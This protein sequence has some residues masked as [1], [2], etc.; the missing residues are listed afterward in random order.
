MNDKVV[1]AGTVKLRNTIKA[2]TNLHNVINGTPSWV[3]NTGGGGFVPSGTIEITENG[4]YNVA[5]YASADVDVQGGITPTGTKQIS[6]TQNGTTTEDVTSYANAEINVNVPASAVDTGTKS[7]NSNGTHDVVGYA[8]ASVNVPN[9]YSAG[10]EGKVVSNGALVA[11]TSDTVTA[12]DTYDTTLINSLTVNVSGGGGESIADFITNQLTTY[13][14]NDIT[15]LSRGAFYYK[16]S[17]EEISLPNCTHIN[18]D[19]FN[20]LSKLNTLYLPKVRIGM[21]NQDAVANCPLLPA[22][23][24]PAY[25]NALSGYCCRGNTILTKLDFGKPSGINSNAFNGQSALNVLV[26]RKS[27]VVSL[28]NISAFT[29]TCFASGKAGG[30]LY[31]PQSLI[32]SYQSATNWSTILG[33]A[34]NQIK[35]IESTHTD[36]TAPIDL[37]L[38]Y[39]DGTLIP[40]T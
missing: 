30:T 2:K 19:V 10:D 8:S 23:A 15:S 25:D 6:I 16:T 35:S 31:V 3:V 11:Q 40:T 24:L 37:T 20:G 27:S 39:A 21:N 9:S 33:Y 5:E 34:N 17:L 26:L 13:S 22:L 12:N 1:I 38:Y 29:N 4:V 28:A 18:R 14:N 36:P 7:I 32:S